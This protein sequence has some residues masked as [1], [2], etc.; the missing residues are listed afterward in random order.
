MLEL[1]VGDLWR[2]VIYLGAF[3]ALAL[4]AIKF[5]GASLLS[6]HFEKSMERFRHD[7]AVEIEKLR[8]DLQESQRNAENK[9]ASSK[10]QL[11]VL[12]NQVLD[13]QS[14]RNDLLERKRLEA[15][16]G[17]W[18]AVLDCDRFGL[19]LQ[20]SANMKLPDILDAASETGSEANK[21]RE[22]GA[23]LVK[24][25][26]LENIKPT[27][28]PEELRLYVS[29]KT[30]SLYSTYAD[31]HFHGVAVLG[32]LKFGQPAN[33]II[34][35]EKLLEDVRKHIPHYSEMIAKFGFEPPRDCRRLQLLRRWSHYEQDNEQIFYRSARTCCAN[36]L[37]P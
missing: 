15:I 10:E 17:V 3:S 33:Y 7:K 30:W 24:I 6:A 4:S 22:F 14:L 26:Q 5:L 35:P 25:S 13:L 19:A 37:G 2:F 1:I 31:L 18:K 12:R 34:G 21:L 27:N 16:E 8:S 29:A 20:F 36:G 23:S 32:A 28:R 11:Q 9:L